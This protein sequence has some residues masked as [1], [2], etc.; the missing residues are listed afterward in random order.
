MT[1]DPIRILVVDDEPPIVDL[2]V[3]YLA[4]EGYEIALGGMAW[5]PWRQG[6]AGG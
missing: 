3:G 5:P 2:L 6:A 1:A 4:R